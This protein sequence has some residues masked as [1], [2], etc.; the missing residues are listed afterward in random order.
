MT[1]SSSAR[2]LGRP[3]LMPWKSGCAVSS[4][5]KT[6][7]TETATVADGKALQGFVLGF[8]EVFVRILQVFV[9]FP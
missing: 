8:P 6:A 3:A 5:C 7:Q 9:G 2:R 1:L 4:P